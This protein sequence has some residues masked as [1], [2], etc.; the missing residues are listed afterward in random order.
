M[1]PKKKMSGMLRSGAVIFVL[2]TSG[3]LYIPS[4]KH[5]TSSE[6]LAVLQVGTTTRAEVL[7]RLGSPNLLDNERFYVHTASSEYGLFLL[8]T[9]GG[10]GGANL[11]GKYYRIL[12]EFDERQILRRREIET[13]EQGVFDRGPIAKKE[14]AGLEPGAWDEKVVLSEKS[15]GM[16][17]DFNAVSISPDGNTLAALDSKERLWLL[18]L[19]TGKHVVLDKPAKSLWH[20]SSAGNQALAFS[21]KGRRLAVLSVGISITDVLDQSK[22]VTFSG[23]GDSCFWI[24]RA[25]TAMTFAPDGKAVAS[26]G[27]DGA[28]R[29]WD[30][31]TG[32]EIRSFTAHEKSVLSLSFSPDGRMLAS[33]GE[34][35]LVRLWDTSSWTEVASIPNAALQRS[36]VVR[37]QPGIARFSPD[38]KILAVNV[39]T[40]VELWP[41]IRSEADSGSPARVSLGK[42]T[43]IFLLPFHPGQRYPGL[44]SAALSFSPDGRMIAASAGAAVIHD[45]AASKNIWRTSD[46]DITDDITDLAFTP[47]G[48][49]LFF[50][51]RYKGVYFISLSRGPL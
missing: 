10:L 34:D 18:D 39:E 36:T 26:G 21:P 20:C 33:S 9:P 44:L 3:C 13:G 31:F 37:R 22:V 41:I 38:G 42:I 12:L 1:G 4:L 40:H 48:Q 8:F 35:S 6:D 28:V 46:A 16:T 19:K 43:D 7:E 29:I 23:H 45:R 15:W 27:S 47:G 25:A 11:G 30:A 14:K 49:T 50:A 5:R 17:L 2:L 51:S 32:A 24:W